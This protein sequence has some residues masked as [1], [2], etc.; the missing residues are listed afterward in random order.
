MTPL[1]TVVEAVFSAESPFS[2]IERAVAV[3]V[4]KHVNGEGAAWPSVRR[5]VE[6]SGFKETVVRAALARLCGEGAVFEREAGGARAGARYAAATYRL[7]DGLEGFATRGARETRGS[8][9]EAEGF[10]TRGLG[11]RHAKTE[12]SR[13]EHIEESGNARASR[14]SKGFATRGAPD[15]EAV[16]GYW[17]DK[18][19]TTVRSKRVREAIER[20]ISQR[21]SEG[22]E[23]RDLQ[24][25]VDFAMTDEFYCGKGYQKQPEVLWRNAE[26][27]QGLLSKADASRPTVV[28]WRPTPDQAE[29][30]AELRRAD[31]ERAA[32]GGRRG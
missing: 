28:A 8:C 30:A 27:V 22:F 11:V 23:A 20:R 2:G 6:C 7:R 21:L 3:A 32:A 19:S 14:R 12:E 13:E 4:A 16:F 18:T 9:G 1:V 26:R 10:A 15:V 24:R 29:A 5:I 31:A 25:V 17:S